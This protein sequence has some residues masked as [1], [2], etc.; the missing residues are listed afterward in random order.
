MFYQ[1]CFP[2]GAHSSH[3][4]TQL[5][6]LGFGIIV[7]HRSISQ[8]Q[9]YG[10]LGQITLGW[11][12]PGYY[13]RM[14]RATLA[15]MPKMLVA[16]PLPGYNNQKHLHILPNIHQGA[17]YGPLPSVENHCFRHLIL[18]MWSM[19]KQRQYRFGGLLEMHNP[20][21]T[22]DLLSQNL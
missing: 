1:K 4:S 14:L 8:P 11:A 19:D 13:C 5:S 12:Y 20:R 9:H 17:R 16:L 6:W 21:P 2:E 18:K 3:Q 7:F 15:P 10:H 22:P